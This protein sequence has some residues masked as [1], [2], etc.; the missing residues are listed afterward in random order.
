VIEILILAGFFFVVFG[1]I[2]NIPSIFSPPTYVV[3]SGMAKIGG[4]I[5]LVGCIIMFFGFMT[6]FL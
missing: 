1:V 4:I 6:F 5:A 3:G 2:L